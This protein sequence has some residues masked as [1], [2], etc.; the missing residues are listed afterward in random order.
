M[1]AALSS[2]LARQGDTVACSSM[3]AKTVPIVCHPDGGLALMQSEPEPARACDKTQLSLRA[4]DETSRRSAVSTP[5]PVTREWAPQPG[6]DGPVPSTLRAPRYDSSSSTASLVYT[7]CGQSRVCTLDVAMIATACLVLWDASNGCVLITSIRHEIWW[8]VIGCT[9]SGLAM[10]PNT[11]RSMEL[12]TGKVFQDIMKPPAGTQGIKEAIGHLFC[13]IFLLPIAAFVAGI[14]STIVAIQAAL[15]AACAG[16][17]ASATSFGCRTYL[18]LE[19]G[20]VGHVSI[21]LL[22]VALM[23]LLLGSPR[24]L[25]SQRI[26]RKFDAL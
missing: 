1:G 6:I 14:A 2:C 23:A 21:C 3:K 25:R 26:V 19:A 24:E 5:S 4:V 7:L 8:F 16:L 11:R 18:Q 9:A 10:V 13:C 17:A 15:I 20:E 22:T 12:T